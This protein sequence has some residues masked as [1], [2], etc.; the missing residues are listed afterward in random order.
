MNLG[1]FVLLIGASPLSSRCTFKNAYVVFLGESFRSGGHQSRLSGGL[2][3]F[4]GQQAASFSQ[5]RFL[6]SAMNQHGIRWQ[7]LVDTYSSRFDQSLRDWYSTKELQNVHFHFHQSPPIGYS[8]LFRHALGLVKAD[9]AHHSN[10]YQFVLFIRIDLYLKDFF[11]VAFRSAV[12]GQ[13]IMFPTATWSIQPTVLWEAANKHVPRVVDTTLYIPA[14]FLPVFF[15]RPSLVLSHSSWKLLRMANVSDTDLGFMIKSQHDSN[16]QND[17]NPLYRMVDRPEC[18]RWQT[19]NPSLDM[20]NRTF[21]RRCTAGCLPT[22]CEGHDTMHRKR[23][24]ARDKMRAK[25][26]QDRLM[27]LSAAALSTNA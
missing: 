19:Y 5:L 11:A 13:Q 23:D 20:F 3:A 2:E 17:W 8:N 1:L 16:S 9:A 27:Q 6:H 7:V 18:S 26:M 12:R 22:F 4:K 10:N 14:S 15:E 25:R 24:M 21:T